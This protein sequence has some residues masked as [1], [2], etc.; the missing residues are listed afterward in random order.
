MFIDYLIPL[1][2]ATVVAALGILGVAVFV[3]RR[4]SAAGDGLAG[5]ADQLDETAL[6]LTSAS[7]DRARIISR[8]GCGD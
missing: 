8:T 6:T 7:R 5:L 1:A 4:L 3:L 2:I